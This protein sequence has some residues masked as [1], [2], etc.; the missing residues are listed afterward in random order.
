MP[1]KRKVTFPN[2]ND[3]ENY[4]WQAN[5]SSRKR[6]LQY[7]NTVRKYNGKPRGRKISLYGEKGPYSNVA[8]NSLWSTKENMTH[9]IKSRT[10]NEMKYLKRVSLDKSHE[11]A[12]FQRNEANKGGNRHTKRAQRN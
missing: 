11:K 9:A 3:N 4:N 10:P 6:K 5:A 2:R 12:L 7:H 8:K 1:T